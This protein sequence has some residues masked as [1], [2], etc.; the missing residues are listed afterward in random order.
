MWKDLSHC[1]GQ[2]DK[3]NL[4]FM[5]IISSQVRQKGPLKNGQMTLVIEANSN[6]NE[7]LYM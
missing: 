5:E 7:F 6:V 2:E 1:S 3:K 4:T